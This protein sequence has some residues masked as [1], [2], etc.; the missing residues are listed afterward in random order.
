MSTCHSC[1]INPDS[2]QKKK[3]KKVGSPWFQHLT[4]RS[5]HLLPSPTHAFSRSSA[6][7]I[8][9]PD[10]AHPGKG[11][12]SIQRVS[13]QRRW[14]RLRCYATAVCTGGTGKF[15]GPSCAQLTGRSPDTW[16][17]KS[18]RE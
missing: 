5:S 13:R 4:R 16:T 11:M 15:E 3:K 8:Y 6:A 1:E 2:S 17:K 7:I 9:A 18:Q 10:A 14:R 12:G